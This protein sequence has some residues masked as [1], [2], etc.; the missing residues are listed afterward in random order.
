VLSGAP[1]ATLVQLVADA[2]A[3]SDEAA[4]EWARREIT[5]RVADDSRV[6]FAVLAEQGRFD[7]I[8]YELARGLRRL[9][10]VK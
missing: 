5:L 8:E 6:T 1:G 2:L 3:V 9:G 7:E 4:V 10:A